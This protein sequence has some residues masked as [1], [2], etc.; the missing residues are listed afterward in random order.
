M[1]E[2]P[3][4]HRNCSQCGRHA[5]RW[6][7]TECDIDCCQECWEKWHKERKI[8][9]HVAWCIANEEWVKR[10]KLVYLQN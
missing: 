6:H 2:T 3:Q 8:Y 1:P 7:C 5:M 10:I 9:N 4:T